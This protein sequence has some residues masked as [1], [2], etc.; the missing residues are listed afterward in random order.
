MKHFLQ[1]F[2]LTPKVGNSFQTTKHHSKNLPTTSQKAFTTKLS[3]LSSMG[4]RPHSPGCAIP[5]RMPHK[6]TWIQAYFRKN[7]Y[8]CHT[9]RQP[10]P[11]DT[12]ELQNNTTGVNWRIS[13]I[14][15]GIF[16]IPLPS[17]KGGAHKD[18][19][20]LR[21][22]E[23]YFTSKYSINISFKEMIRFAPWSKSPWSW[24][25]SSK[26]SWYSPS[27][28]VSSRLPCLA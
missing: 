13:D 7:S 5:A 17:P 12:G 24:H 4:A 26:I 21:S 20:C 15:S 14:S 6:N 25:R 23:C 9:Q 27:L 28:L 16:S 2:Y 11:S 19:P 1:L 3:S 22:M 8:L 10:L 18:K